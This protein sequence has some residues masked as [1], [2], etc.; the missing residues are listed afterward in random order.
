MQTQTTPQNQAG[1]E[2]ASAPVP[3]VPAEMDA[4]LQ[5]RYG[6]SE[7]LEQGRIA[8]PQPGEGEVLLRVRAAGLDRGTWHLMSGK[9]YLVRFMFG[10]RGPKLPVPGLDVAGTVVALGEGVTD[11]AIGDEV[12]GVAT[13]SFAEYAVAPTAKLVKRPESLSPEAAAAVP[14]SG[15]TALQAVVDEGRVRPGQKVL[16]TGASGGVGNYAVQIAV[17]SGAEVTGVASAGK[18]EFLRSLGAAHTVDYRTTDVTTLDERFDLIIDINGRAPIRRLRRI[19][20]PEGTLVMVGGEDGGWFMGGFQRQ[21]SA[22]LRN[23]FTTQRILGFMSAE[24]KE[25]IERLATM[26]VAGQVRPQVSEAY[27]IADVRRAMDD[28]VGGR[29]SGKA[30]ITVA[31]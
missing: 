25:S 29:V 17:A 11:L 12:F 20:A 21:L 3:A 13:G 15:M 14:V 30:V 5:H 31:V 2:Q 9:P 19:L 23:A 22:P 8:V 4:V 16:V 27:P 6:G 28:L 26:I 18:A 24:R 1:A 10:F 7:M